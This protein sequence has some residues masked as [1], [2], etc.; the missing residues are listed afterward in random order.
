MERPLLQKK[1]LLIHPLIMLISLNSLSQSSKEI[2]NIK[3]ENKNHAAIADAILGS[4]R[5]RT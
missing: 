3:I 5:R 2:I 1:W 4:E